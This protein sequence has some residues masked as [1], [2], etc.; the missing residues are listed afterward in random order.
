MNFRHAIF[1]ISLIVVPALPATAASGC[2]PPQVLH[3]MQMVPL[4]DGRIAV[5]V[6]FGTTPGTLILDS[7]DISDPPT[8]RARPRNKTVPGINNG[9]E[10]WRNY[11]L[12]SYVGIVGSLT[13]KTVQELG[14][15]PNNTGSRIM[16]GDRDRPEK[17]VTVK[18]FSFQ[19]LSPFRTQF[20]VSANEGSAADYSGTFSI[21]N[22]KQFSFDIDLDFVARTVRFFSRDHCR[23][24]AVDWS[25][26]TI[27][28]LK[29]T[30]DG[31]GYIRF[32]VTLDGKKLS[33]LLDTGSP[34]TTLDFGY[35]SRRWRVRKDDPALTKIGELADGRV[36]YSRPF[37]SIAIGD[38]SVT[39]PTIMLVPGITGRSEGPPTG[40][41]IDLDK[42]GSLPPLIIGMSVLR[43]LRVHIAFDEKRLYF[44][45]SEAVSP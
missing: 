16:V 36:V 2:K 5:P 1:V 29:F 20:L 4:R 23:R 32:P 15:T 12:P 43:Q 6:T 35:A 3:S 30:I 45:R 9:V 21:N 37:Q 17:K 10:D 7:T 41:R 34:L 42:R 19:G 18:Q 25:A 31:N 13:M 11:N 44:A 33:A 8:D 14:L 26:S 22:F 27:E 39:D 28:N 38:I 40:S 24:R